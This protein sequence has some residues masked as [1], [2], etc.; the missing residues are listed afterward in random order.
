MQV[1]VGSVI[2]QLAVSK[3]QHDVG[4]ISGIVIEI[5]IYFIHDVKTMVSE[6]IGVNHLT[7]FAHPPAS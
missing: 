3:C 7:H 4:C 2:R 5:V 1:K 6:L